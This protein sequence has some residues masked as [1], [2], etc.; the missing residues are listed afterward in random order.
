MVLRSEQTTRRLLV[1]SGEPRSGRRATRDG[2]RAGRLAMSVE[3]SENHK[4]DAENHHRTS[5]IRR[6]A[7]DSFPVERALLLLVETLTGRVDR[8]ADWVDSQ[9]PVALD[10][11]RVLGE[12]DLPVVIPLEEHADRSVADRFVAELLIAKHCEARVGCAAGIDFAAA[13][14]R[15]AVIPADPERQLLAAL[16]AGRIAECD[17][18]LVFFAPLPTE[19]AALTYRLYELSIFSADAPSVAAIV[20]FSHSSKTLPSIAPHVQQERPIAPLDD[21]ALVHQVFGRLAQLP[22]LSMIVGVD[23]MRPGRTAAI[24]DPLHAMVAGGPRS[25]HGTPRGS[26]ECRFRGRSRTRSSRHA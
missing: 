7:V 26:L 4:G 14:P 6:A 20:A 10:G 21:R 2:G 18:A 25:V 3:D 24:A 22:G 15:A 23:H 8:G 17:P 9:L 19:Q 11:L 16:L 5:A 13:R 12:A 1:G